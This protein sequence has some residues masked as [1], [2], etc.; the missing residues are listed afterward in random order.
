MKIIMV[1]IMTLFL[2]GCG[3]STNQAINIA[4]NQC[5]SLKKYTKEQMLKALSEIQKLPSETQI[6]VLLNDY[7]KLRDACRLAEKKLK[8]I[9]NRTTKNK[10]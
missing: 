2:A 5:P 8:S 4:V 7:S 10:K 3:T 9:R 1:V 6:S